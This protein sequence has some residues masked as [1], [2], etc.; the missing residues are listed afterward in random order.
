MAIDIKKI[1]ADAFLEL[2]SE[3]PLSK[4]KIRDLL[5]KSGASKQSFYN[6]FLDKNDLICY[7][8]DE[9][10]IPEFDKQKVEVDF[11]EDLL[12]DFENMKKYSLFMKQACLE[13]GQNCLKDHIYKHIEEFDLKWHQKAYGDMR[14]PKAME[15]A[16]RYHAQASASMTLSWI[17]G[18]MPVEP[19]EIANLITQMRKIGMKEYFKTS[20]TGINPYL[21]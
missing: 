8:Y 2:L 10:I 12:R 17:L 1:F 9:K 4:I 11:K 14:M 19:K 21:D 7:I 5:E 13:E 20:S 16:T 3:K 18:D 6:H 15:F